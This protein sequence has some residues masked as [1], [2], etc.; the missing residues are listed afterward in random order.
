VRDDVPIDG[1]TVRAYRVPTDL[2]ESDG[3]FEWSSTTMV[4]V[5]A[6]AGGKRGIGYSYTAAAAGN[7]IREILE[8]HVVGRSALDV[9]ACYDAMVGAV[10]NIG[11][12]GLAMTAVSAVDAALWDLKG[13]LLGLPLVSVLGACRGSVAVYGSGG[14]TSYS[15]AE[16]AGQLGG[17]VADGISRV[18]M[19][20]GRET[21]RDPLRVRV[22]REAIGHATELFVDANGG[23]DRKEAL[24]KAE[25]FSAG[26]VNWFEEP[27]VSRDMEGLRLIRDRASA[28]MEIAAG[29]YGFVLDDFRELLERGCV[30]V[31][32]ADATRCGITGFL[33]AAALCEGFHIPLSSHC[34]PSLHLHVCCAG[35]PVRHMEYFH[36]HVRIERMFFD[37]FRGQ[38][39]GF[40]SPDLSRPGLGLE[41]K[42]REAENFAV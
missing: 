38:S 6:D 7:L 12:T 36:D 28:G 22:A 26:G 15:D 18:K 33:R 17:W 29:E 39:G 40:M 11:A 1:L 37:G 25:A 13:K 27:V 10:R 9:P 3:T 30:D 21:Y 32:Q 42:E 2:P 31:L 4:V 19:K 14:F 16:L 5:H 34:A 20:V 35:T 8:R 41:L 23:Y 24:A